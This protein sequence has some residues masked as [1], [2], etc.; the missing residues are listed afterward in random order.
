MLQLR[1]LSYVLSRCRFNGLDQFHLLAFD[2]GTILLNSKCYI[3]RA[4]LNTSSP[5]ILSFSSSKPISIR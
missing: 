1:A 2:C 4:K 5:T 3:R